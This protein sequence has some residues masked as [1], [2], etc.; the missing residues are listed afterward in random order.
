VGLF[1]FPG[2]YDEPE[3]R[4]I[5]LNAFLASET[6]TP[7]IFSSHMIERETLFESCSVTNRGDGTGRVSFPA[8]RDENIQSLFLQPKFSF[9]VSFQKETT[10][11]KL[12]KL[13]YFA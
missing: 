2:E 10:E 3:T 11:N 6:I 12:L 1:C 4:G 9:V 13:G 8:S 7:G 5:A